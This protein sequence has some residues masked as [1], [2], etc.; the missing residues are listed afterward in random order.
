[1]ILLARLAMGLRDA[2]VE[3]V[4][5]GVVVAGVVTA[6]LP[7]GRVGL[8]VRV[9]VRVAAPRAL[10]DGTLAVVGS[11]AAVLLPAVEPARRLGCT[12]GR[13]TP[14][15]AESAERRAAVGR[16]RGWAGGR[17]R[18]CLRGCG[19]LCWVG[20]EVGV[21]M[22]GRRVV[23]VSVVRVG[24]VMGMRGVRNVL[25]GRSGMPRLLVLA[26]ILGVRGLLVPRVRPEP[27]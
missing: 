25:A 9:R 24:L 7:A 1:V 23:R 16:R 18:R 6:A 14:E 4:R 15:A 13:A 2:G 10:R 22:V 8:S 12:A 3:G 5:L 26:P 27:A 20:V 19:L 11:L 21:V 17:L